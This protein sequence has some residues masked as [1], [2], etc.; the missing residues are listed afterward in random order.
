[1]AADVVTLLDYIGWKEERDLHVV[2]ISLG[3]M[4]AQGA[5]GSLL[6]TLSC[7]RHTLELASAIPE[8]IVSLSL[9]VTTP[10]GYFWNNLPPVRLIG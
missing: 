5:Y 2:G 7:L 8:R 1:M 3:G 9:V 4:I 6:V 10:G